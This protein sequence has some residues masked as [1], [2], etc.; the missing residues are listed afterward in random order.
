M[1]FATKDCRINKNTP[2]PLRGC[3]KIDNLG[4]KSSLR[5]KPES[6]EFKSIWKNWIPAFAGMTENRIFR[7]F[8]T[9]SRFVLEIAALSR[10]GGIAR[11][12]WLYWAFRYSIISLPFVPASAELVIG[13]R[14]TKAWRGNSIFY[15]IMNFEDE[16]WLSMLNLSGQFSTPGDILNGGKF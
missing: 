12:D 16:K 14:H 6:R 2:F 8:T 11:D 1:W 9:P 13:S 7:L 15:E 4:K 5:W 10:H 3:V